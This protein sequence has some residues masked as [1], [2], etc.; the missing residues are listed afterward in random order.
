MDVPTP[1]K[2]IH[3]K[4]WEDILEREMVLNNNGVL[5]MTAP[6][7]GSLA[8]QTTIAHSNYSQRGS[9][10]Y[11]KKEKRERKRERECH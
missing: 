1:S 4:F 5:T 6:L 9:V 7:D 11:A 2:A 3:L 8:H 10:H